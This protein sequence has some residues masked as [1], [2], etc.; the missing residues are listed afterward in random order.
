LEG[1][2]HRCLQSE[3]PPRSLQKELTNPSPYL[4]LG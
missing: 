2:L 4:F 1:N 3:V